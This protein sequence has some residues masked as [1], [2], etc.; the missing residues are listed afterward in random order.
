MTEL[1][2]SSDLNIIT[3]EINSYKQVAGQS[4]FE[5]GKRLKHVK[6]NDLVHGQW[7][8]WLGSIDV[9]P[10]TATRFIQVFEQFGN[11]T[12]SYGL[13]ASKMFEMLSLPESVDREAFVQK[14]H[15]VP[16]TGERKTVDEMTVRELREVK[17]ALQEAERRAKSAEEKLANMKPHVVIESVKVIPDD[18]DD[19]KQQAITAQ[20]L[21]NENVVL[22]RKNQELVQQLTSARN[23]DV[24]LRKVREQCI[25][26]MRELTGNHTVMIM[27]ISKLEGN[28]EAMEIINEY[29]SRLTNFVNTAIRDLNEFAQIKQTNGGIEIEYTIDTSR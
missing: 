27:E 15:T 4:L 2:L 6:E 17:K 24:S 19:L 14:E 22:N 20:R 10:Q 1:A 25:H 26:I 23:A 12:T 28:A 21:N 18:Y 11:R 9:T 3:A 29:G 5:I 7:Y 16:S 13:P 8:E